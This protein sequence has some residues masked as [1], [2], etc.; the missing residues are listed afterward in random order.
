VGKE[1]GLWM[2]KRGRVNGLEKRG[3]IKVGKGKE[4]RMV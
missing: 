3:R 1:G 2:G 4:L